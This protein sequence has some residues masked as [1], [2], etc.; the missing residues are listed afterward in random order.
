MREAP[1]LIICACAAALFATSAF[2]DF[3]YA[4]ATFQAGSTGGNATYGGTEQ[5]GVGAPDG[6]YITL[7]SPGGA[8]TA[9]L[10]VRFATNVQNPGL[11]LY[12]VT[13]TGSVTLTNLRWGDDGQAQAGV[14]NF[15]DSTSLGP[16][17]VTNGDF[18]FSSGTF[19]PDFSG[20]LYRFAF[21]YFSLTAN[22]SVQIDAVSNPE[23]GSA[24]LFALGGLGLGAWVLRSRRRPRAG[25]ALRA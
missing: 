17:T 14:G 18:W 4:N 21:V 13:V 15:V 5:N 22:S 2:G 24:A 3:Q 1:R 25:R 10:R 6:V 7:S 8:G 12:G 20:G 16:T 11:T 19:T 9:R 23:P